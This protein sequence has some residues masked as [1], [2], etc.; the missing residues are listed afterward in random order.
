MKVI[1]TGMTYEI[2]DNELKTFDKLPVQCYYMR[3]SPMKG[4]YLEKL[5]DMEIK[6][7]KI[8]GVHN[9]K[10][11][12]VLDNF[13]GFERN[14][15]VILSG[16]KGIGKSLFARLLAVRAMERG[17]PVIVIENYYSGL[18]AFIES[19]EQEVVIIFD[20][21]E[22]VFGAERN[23]DPMDDSDYPA[24]KQSKLLSL[25]DGMSS[26]KKL[27]VITCNRFDHLDN[28]LIGRPG[29]FH[30]HFVF[31][32][33]NANEIREYLR[34]KLNEEYYGEIDE[35]VR[36][37]YRVKLNYD[38][39]RA[40]AYELNTG[41]R[42]KDA[43]GDLN[44]STDFSAS[45]DYAVQAELESGEMT[46]PVTNFIS[47][48][49][50]EDRISVH[51]DNTDREYHFEFKTADAILDLERGVYILPVDKAIGARMQYSDPEF[52]ENENAAKVL[53]SKGVKQL[54]FTRLF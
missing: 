33:P 29:R 15:G 19:I 6:E 47:F 26:G 20:E 11:K 31:D 45:P 2:F 52:R 3:F 50:A 51:L 41:V 43:I 39:L 40:I 13:E 42:F 9:A 34:D 36:F 14:L 44:I 28:N 24:S 53:K 10:A 27:F 48:S 7:E 23:S 25:F 18:A 5:G 37:A 21:F 8:Y 4:F 17:L 1:K 32:Y 49:H 30:Y 35:V 54:V 12:K 38:C 46:E 22:K 16:D